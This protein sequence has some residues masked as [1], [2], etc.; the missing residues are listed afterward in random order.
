[1]VITL[2]KFLVLLLLFLAI[3]GLIGWAIV[4]LH[5]YFERPKSESP[6]SFASYKTDTTLQTAAAAE[7]SLVAARTAVERESATLQ[8]SITNGLKHLQ[9]TALRQAHSESVKLAN[10]WYAQKHQ[11]ISAR[12]SVSSGLA[13]L[14]R[15][16]RNLA[17]RR[18]RTR[19]GQRQQLVAELS[20]IQV[21]IDSHYAA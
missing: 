7:R 8:G 12:R 9:F 17:Q 14:K 2:V 19:V 15:H 1:M 18:D 10:A 4:S 6:T 20:I 16:K 21:A 5:L 13:T 3:I 11:A